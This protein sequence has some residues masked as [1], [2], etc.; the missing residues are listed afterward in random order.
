MSV[1]QGKADISEDERAGLEL[2]C[3]RGETHQNDF[4]KELDVSPRKGSLLVEAISRRWRP[5]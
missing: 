5:Q 3:E 2:V 1:S 4:R